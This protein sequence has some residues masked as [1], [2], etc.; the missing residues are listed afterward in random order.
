MPCTNSSDYQ[1]DPHK[2]WQPAAWPATLK[3]LAS[4]LRNYVSTT[5][6]AFKKAGVDL[7]IVSLGNEVRYGMLWSLG[8]ADVDVEPTKARVANFTN[9]ATL[10]QAARS[11]VRDAVAAGVSKPEVMIHI[12]NGWNL[13]LQE[14]WS[15]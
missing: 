12:G 2:Q 6:Q 13:T 15:S 5:L 1:A 14:R 10:Y 7:S 8:W 11:G 3:A 9:L 4:E